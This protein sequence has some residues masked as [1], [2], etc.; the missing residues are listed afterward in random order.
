MKRDL[1][2]VVPSFPSLLSI[3]P[4]SLPFF[5]GKRR[6]GK[7]HREIKVKN[8]ERI[9]KVNDSHQGRRQTKG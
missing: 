6:D 2:T 3:L 8:L 1:E 7:D 4:S 9:K 5:L